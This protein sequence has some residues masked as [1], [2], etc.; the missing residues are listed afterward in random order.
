MN[1][2]SRPLHIVV[3]LG[4]LAFFPAAGLADLSLPLN[5]NYRLGRYMPVRFSG[6]GS[7]ILISADGAV[8][9]EITDAIGGVAPFLIYRSPVRGASFSQPLHELSADERLIGFTTDASDIGKVLF[10]GETV[11]PVQLDGAAPIPGPTTAWESLDALVLDSSGKLTSDQITALLAGGTAIAVKAD[12]PTSSAPDT[13]WPWALEHGFW[14]LHAPPALSAQASDAAYQPVAGWD[15]GEPSVYRRHIVLLAVVFAVLLLGI[16]LLRTWWSPL[17]AVALA[18]AA[19]IFVP[20]WD[21]MQSPISTKSGTVCVQ[22]TPAVAD[23]WVYQG[24]YRDCENRLRYSG[25]AIPILPE[26]GGPQ[27]VTLQCNT[28]GIPLGFGFHLPANTPGVFVFRAVLPAP[29]ALAPAQPITT[30]LRMLLPQYYA[31]AP[32]GEIA[33]TDDPVA[34]LTQWPALVVGG[35]GVGPASSPAVPK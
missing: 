23:T 18:A 19:V 14:V 13:T 30:P 25:L 11:I 24:A 28:V 29:P 20:M 15:Q 2:L 10:P 5:G 17:I 9:T 16:A 33:S 31:G 12:S 6:S 26:S 8:T 3:V 7:Q 22:G 1:L 4:L 27:N 34:R 32:L 35:A 21:A